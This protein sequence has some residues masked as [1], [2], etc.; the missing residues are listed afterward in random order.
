MSP[1]LNLRIE[2]SVAPGFESVR[3]LY[4]RN[5]NT[6]R[7]RNTQLCVYHRGEQVVDLWATAI[8]DDAFTPDTLV[9]VFSS[10]KSMEAIALAS[11][12]GKGLLDYEKK[13][14]DYWPEFAQNGKQD[15]TVADL[16]RHEG[17]MAGFDTPIDP[18]SLL[19]KNIKKNQIGSVIETHP[20]RF[21][22]R[23]DT[24]RE[25][26]AITRGWIANEVFRRIDPAGRTIGE[27]LREEVSEPLETDAYIGLREPELPRVS[28]VII[29]GFLWTF[30][31]SL[32]PRF[33]GR[34][35]EPNFFRLVGRLI[36]ILNGARGGTSAKAAPPFKGFK[37]IGFD[38]FN[39]REVRMG[40]TPSANTHSTAR[41]LA[42]IAAMI[43]GG[44]SLSGTR[45]LPGESVDALH[46]DTIPADM[47]I[48]PTSFS[49]GGVNE[50]TPTTASSKDLDRGLNEGRAGFFGW[51]GFGG[52]VFQWH[53]EL[54][55]GFGYVPTSLFALDLFNERGKGYQCEVVRCVEKLS[56][57]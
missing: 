13:I 47:L 46:A 19:T 50:F 23:D 3:D 57:R 34:K 12:H 35:I 55:I 42:K 27:Y 54:E 45:C 16:M 24:R 9:N 51:M 6:Y 29:L 22:K 20:V 39:S 14:A 8:G 37:G 53:R 44:G 5:M 48:M 7:E 36:R 11:L 32:V 52:S 33:L 25:Y 49:Q 56:A 4:E 17:G 38:A 43:A 15:L 41:G 21:P 30:L 26:H 40:E 18:E 31:Q 2:G 10:G 1:S 28:P